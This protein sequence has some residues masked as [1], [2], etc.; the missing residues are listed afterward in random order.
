MSKVSVGE[1][2]EAYKQISA[3]IKQQKINSGFI[4]PEIDFD[5]DSNGK[6][7]LIAVEVNTEISLTKINNLAKMIKNNYKLGVCN[8]ISVGSYEDTTLLLLE[9][10]KVSE[11]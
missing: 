8:V 3:Y 6:V 11:K 1:K 5:L 10:K 7:E 4:E 2:S 9:F